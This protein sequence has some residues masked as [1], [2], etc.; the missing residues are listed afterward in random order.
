[1]LAVIERSKL[2]RPDQDPLSWS[3][4]TDRRFRLKHA[5]RIPG[6]ALLA[7]LQGL[8]ATES[9]PGSTVVVAD[10]A[11]SG[12]LRTDNELG[13]RLIVV[14]VIE[15]A[16]Q[17]RDG[18]RFSVSRTELMKGLEL[19]LRSRKLHGMSATR[20]LAEDDTALAVALAWWRADS[21]RRR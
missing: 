13:F 2:M 20:A 6:S 16:E 1:V 14:P 9:V 19:A 15:A 3:F 21:D 11:R 5:A 10:A 4:R 18:I 12:A 17:Q 7:H 8:I